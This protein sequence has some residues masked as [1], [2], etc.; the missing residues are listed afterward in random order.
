MKRAELRPSIPPLRAN[1]VTLKESYSCDTTPKTHRGR[2]AKCAI[3][4]QC[5]TVAA[6]VLLKYRSMHGIRGS[7]GQQPQPGEFLA[8][9]SLHFAGSQREPSNGTKFCPIHCVQ[10][11]PLCVKRRR[12]GSW[13]AYGQV[14]IALVVN[15]V[16]EATA[17]DLMLT[18]E[19]LGGGLLGQ[20]E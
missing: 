10:R 15:D 6:Q 19:L 11:P 8:D 13:R 5:A 1:I 9:K 7:W 16:P 18:E 4:A 20:L 2:D 14:K 3:A 17:Q 12:A